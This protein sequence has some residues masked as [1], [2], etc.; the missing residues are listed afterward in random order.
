M[1]SKLAG[2]THCGCVQREDEE[3]RTRGRRVGK[4]EAFAICNVLLS[5]SSIVM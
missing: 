5:I 4:K 3:G 2:K 1:Q